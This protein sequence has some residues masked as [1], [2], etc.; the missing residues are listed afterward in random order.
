MS[1]PKSFAEAAT[2]L[3][4]QILRAKAMVNI[5]VRMVHEN[6]EV[7][8]TEEGHDD[9][10]QLMSAVWDAIHEMPQT[11]EDLWAAHRVVKAQLE[12]TQEGRNEA[13]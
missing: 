8:S 11:S 7:I 4:D 10:L 2:E 6:G 3:D 9:M 13:A 1:K 12:L 5:M